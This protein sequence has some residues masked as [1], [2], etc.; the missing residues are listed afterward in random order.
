V[1]AEEAYR[2]AKLQFGSIEST[3]EMYR[4]HRGLPAF[5]AIA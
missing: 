1:S 2:R 3:K 5:D 4:D